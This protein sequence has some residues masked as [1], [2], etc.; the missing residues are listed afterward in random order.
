MS[1]T[2]RRLTTAQWTAF[3][4]VLKAGEPAYDLTTDTV[5]IGDGVSTWTALTALG[6]GGGGGG[7]IPE[8]LETASKNLGASDYTAEQID[9]ETLVITYAS[10]LVKTI[11]DTGTTVTVTL[12]GVV[13][14]GI[15]TVKTITFTGDDF[16]GVYT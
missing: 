2:F 9:A 12:S 10:G 3:N 1:R 13:P 15:D 16:A 6:G 7:G 11:V 4:P 14:G 5:K 8:S